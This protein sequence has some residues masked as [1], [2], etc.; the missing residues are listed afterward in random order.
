MTPIR[1]LALCLAPFAFVVS[2][3]LSPAVRAQPGAPVPPGVKGEMLTWIQDAENKLLELLSA[4][5]ESKFSWRP[6]KGVRS[7]AEVF[8]HVA[9][10]NYGL[11][12]F[13]GVQPPPEFKFE[14]FEKSATKKADVEKALKDSYVHM[15]KAFLDATEADLNKPIEFFGM[16]STVRGAYMLLLA[17]GQEHLGQA[18]AYARMNKIAPPW[19]ARMNEKI[20]AAQKEA[21]SKTE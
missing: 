13:A 3:L 2:M 16:K 21:K 1:K 12:G 8:M 7:T 11:P 17:H 14:T 4:T 6:G 9:T 20:K 5:P 18:I 19:T 15:K 10:A